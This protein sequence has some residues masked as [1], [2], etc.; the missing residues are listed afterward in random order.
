MMSDRSHRQINVRKIL[1][2]TITEIIDA[3]MSSSTGS[4]PNQ[5]SSYEARSADVASQ[6]ERRVMH[7]F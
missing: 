6:I 3:E 4:T 2:T 7:I 5:P 1:D